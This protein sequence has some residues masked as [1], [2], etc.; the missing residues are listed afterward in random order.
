MSSHVPTV[1]AFVM[2]GGAGSRLRPLTDERCKPALPF[3]GNFRVVDFVLG[4]LLNSGIHQV[5]LLVQYQPRVLVSHVVETWC[6]RFIAAGG[7]L[8]IAAPASTGRFR[9]TADAVRQ[10]LARLWPGRR[11]LALVFGADHVYRMD[12]NQMIDFHLRRG[13]DATVS[14]LPVPLDEASDF[15][16]ADVDDAGRVRRFE[17]KPDDPCAMPGR[18]DRALASMGNYV[19]DLDVL[20]KELARCERAGEHDF[21]HHVLPRLIDSHRVFAYD[22]ATNRVPGTLPH[23]EPGYWR[24]IGTLDAYFAAQLDALGTRPRFNLDN[25][26]WPLPCAAEQGQPPVVMRSEVRRSCIAA[27]AVV[28]GAMLDEVVVGRGARVERGAQLERC[29]VFEGARVGAGARLRGVLVDAGAVVPPGTTIGH[30]EADDRRR[31]VCSSGGLVVVPRGRFA[32]A[33]PARHEGIA[34]ASHA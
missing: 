19:F 12:V 29:M 6:A 31:F 23:E 15:G 21:G 1:H 2:A 28:D 24:D 3:G 10:Q 8:R 25:P 22:F 33:E 13:A 18:P 34:L 26:R 9:G 11:G 14:T 30:D 20:R 27:D 32:Q 16:V 5:D 4:N 17:E 7:E